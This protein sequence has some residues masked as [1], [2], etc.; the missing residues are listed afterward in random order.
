MNLEDR[1]RL[2]TL[3]QQAGR[4]LFALTYLCDRS[5]RL[6]QLRTRSCASPTGDP[7]PCCWTDE[8]QDHCP[9]DE[10]NNQPVAQS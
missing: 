8:K 9:E 7:P 4:H 10:E 2:L 3:L 6:S 5:V 1:S